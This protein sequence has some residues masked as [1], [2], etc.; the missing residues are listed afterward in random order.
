MAMRCCPTCIVGSF[1]EKNRESKSATFYLT[2]DHFRDIRQPILALILISLV[3]D[4][5]GIC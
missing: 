2:C 1:N 3:S 4:P 5:C